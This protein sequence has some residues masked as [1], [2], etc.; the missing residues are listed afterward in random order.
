MNR[1]IF[2]RL[3]IVIS[4]IGLL[5]LAGCSPAGLLALIGPAAPTVTQTPA[6]AAV[7]PTTTQSQVIATPVP[8]TALLTQEQLLADLYQRVNPSVVNITVTEGSG[9][10]AQQGTGSG[11]VYDDKGHIVTNNH[12]VADATKIWVTFADG[13]M[14]PAKIVGTDPGTDLAVIQVDR[15]ARE[16]HPVTLGDSD[17]LQVGQLAVAIGNPFGLEGTM[18]VGIIS[19]LGRVLSAASSGFAI[20]DLIQTDAPINPG[21]SGGPLLDV[22]GRVIGVNTLIFSQTGVSSGVGLAVPVAAVKRV[23]PALI[24]KGHY[25]H[26]WLGISGRSITPALAEALELPVQQG[27]L[28]ELTV[29]GGPAEQAGIQGGYRRTYVDGLPVTIGGDII[30]AVDGAEV[31]SFDDLVGY[32]ARRTEVGQQITLTLLRNGSQLKVQVRLE[33]RP[34]G[35]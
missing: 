16:L 11:F 31:K 30:V 23:V 6:T 26:P 28:V 32:L 2:F 29:S 5:L 8:A 4:L 34:A 14:L 35:G 3:L 17:T 15:P 33:E 13:T 9:S 10:F 22:G 27:A 24:E 19:A 1:S 25:A 20:V 12:V 18:T 7:A 21:N